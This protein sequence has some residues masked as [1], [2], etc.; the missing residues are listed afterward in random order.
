M[1]PPKIKEKIQVLSEADRILMDNLQNR[2]IDQRNMLAN[3]KNDIQLLSS[4]ISTDKDYLQDTQQRLDESRRRIT[5][6]E[7]GFKEIRI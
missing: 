3:S 4:K 6:L 7:G 1:P 5:Y 2:L